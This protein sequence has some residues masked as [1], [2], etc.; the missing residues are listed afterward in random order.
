MSP[1]PKRSSV[2]KSRK[3][4]AVSPGRASYVE[5]G[6]GRSS[7]TLEG[8]SLE[9]HYRKEELAKA[10]PE[11]DAARQ[12]IWNLDKATIAEVKSYNS[13]PRQVGWV[14]NAV[15]LLLGQEPTWANAKRLMADPNFKEKLRFVN[16]ENIPVA[17]VRQLQKEY[18]QNPQFTP[19][20]IAQV[21]AAAGVLCLWV[22][23]I[24][25]YAEILHGITTKVDHKVRNSKVV[26]YVR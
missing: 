11:L 22:R 8:R 18:L 21:S 2:R 13:P 16:P 10:K 6:D 26:T 23:A 5:L 20:S 9:Q 1:S 25:T 19:Q 7:I 15:M 17:L 14:V 24:T 4:T 12:A 3:T